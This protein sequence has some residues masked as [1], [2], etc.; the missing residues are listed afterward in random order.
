M[1][2]VLGIVLCAALVALGG[3][4]AEAAE[5]MFLLDRLPPSV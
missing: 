2:R 5:G 1:T 4:A 3:G